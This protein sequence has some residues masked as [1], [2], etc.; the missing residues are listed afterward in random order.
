[1]GDGED[2][3]QEDDGDDELAERVDEGRPDIDFGAA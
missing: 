1:L 3:Q 2:Q